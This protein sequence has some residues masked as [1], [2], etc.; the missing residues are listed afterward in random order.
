MAQ[1]LLTTIDNEYNPFTQWDQWYEFDTRMG[2]NTCALLGYFSYATSDLDE[3]DYEIETNNAIDRVLAFNP[4]GRHMK[5]Y[6]YEAE[7]L[8]P[9]AN[10]IFK[11]SLSKEEKT[12]S[13]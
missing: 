4:F 12:L 9:L 1:C 8:I 13:Q 6:D 3:E 10:K 11:E 5:V 2:Y 7:T